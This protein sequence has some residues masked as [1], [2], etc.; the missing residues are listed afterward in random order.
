MTKDYSELFVLSSKIYT[1]LEEITG[2]KFSGDETYGHILFKNLG[3]IMDVNL[4]HVELSFFD[5]PGNILLD[6]GV[7]LVSEGG[8]EF[9]SSRFTEYSDGSI[10]ILINRSY[11]HD[12][13][14]LVS[15]IVFEIARL[16][17]RRDGK[18]YSDDV[19]SLEVVLLLFGFGIFNANSSVI[20]M[21][22]WFN[23]LKSESY[24]Y[25]GPSQL[26][27][28]AHG[29]L[30]ALYSYYRGENNPDWVSYL[31]KEI[32]KAYYIGLRYLRSRSVI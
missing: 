29:F 26:S 4:K 6:S 1:D 8:G 16:K 24:M 14:C 10:E 31:E 28:E 5:E 2:R 21:E 25:K 19:V 11:L 17:L 32:S 22:A 9:A 3:A 30:M 27:P 20:K 13:N 7:V 12:S 18:E 23:D 15:A